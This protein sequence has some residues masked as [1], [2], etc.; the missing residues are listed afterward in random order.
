[1][2]IHNIL[3][4]F[5]SDTLIYGIGGMFSRAFAFF[6]IP[7][8]ISYLDKA[9]YANLILLQLI[10]TICSFF[11]ALNSGVFFYY[12]EYKREKIKRTVFSSWLAYEL[13]T[14]FFILLITV[15]IYPFLISPIFTPPE[16]S[17]ITGETFFLPFLVIILQL[18]PFIIFNT[19][20]NLL[21]IQLKP[22]RA[23]TLTILDAILVI[24]FVVYFLVY[25]EMGVLGVVLGQLIAKSILAIGILAVGF[26]KYLNYSLVSWAMIK[27]MF[28]YSSPFFL[29]SIFLWIMNSSDKIIG[30]QLLESKA[31]V[32]FLG[33]GMQITMPVIMLVGIISQAFGP[34]V[35]SIRHNADANQ[36]YREIFSFSIYAS[37][38][39]STLLLTISPFLID[40]LADDTFYPALIVI[41]LFV[42]ASMIEIAMTLLALGLNLTKKTL[43]IA[44]ATIIGGII[45]FAINIYFQPILGIQTAGYAQILAF[46]V[47]TVIV[48]KYSQKFMYIDYNL[49]WMFG[50]LTILTG[51]IFLLSITNR[52]FPQNPHLPYLAIGGITFVILLV[53]GERKYQGL[54]LVKVFYNKYLVK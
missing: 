3:K 18:L 40:I 39:I 16:N 47:T 13:V 20:F 7:L 34:Y 12:S 37:A 41:P 4:G 45:G 15:L 54:E 53:I 23:V 51:C 14:F 22:Q 8:Y 24:V 25:A 21:R 6:L 44:I 49:K 38:V 52:W 43:Y 33:L 28:I 27:R 29:G 2:S 26:Y 1:M 36:T 46:A 32:A 11:L 9:Q 42:L 10:F 48:Y 17:A 30:T 5:V 31:E 19:Y 35:M 50:L